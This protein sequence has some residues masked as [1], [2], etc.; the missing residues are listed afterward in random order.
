MKLFD[1][2]EGRLGKSCDYL[3]WRYLAKAVLQI[4]EDIDAG[5][6]LGPKGDA[7]SWVLCS[8]LR[9]ELHNRVR[10]RWASLVN[11]DN[12]KRDMTWWPYSED[13]VARLFLR[14]RKR[15]DT[16]IAGFV[17]EVS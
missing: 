2:D 6:V 8:I 10:E 17:R 15:N 13:A 11:E 1:E 14:I 7:D 9:A 3:S 4:K 12:P 16:E 5:K